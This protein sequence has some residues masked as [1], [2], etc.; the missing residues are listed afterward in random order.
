M[1]PII[2]ALDHLRRQLA[3]EA[4]EQQQARQQLAIE[5]GS[6]DPCRLNC[7]SCEPAAASS[8]DAFVGGGGGGE[9]SPAA[10]DDDPDDDEDEYVL[11]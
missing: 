10:A 1:T 6:D 5:D 11:C 3:I 4:A 8:A 7:G 2:Y 9:G